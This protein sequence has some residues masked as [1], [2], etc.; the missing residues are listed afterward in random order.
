MLKAIIK[1][2]VSVVLVVLLYFN[3]DFGFVLREMEEISLSFLTIVLL[4]SAAGII[5]EVIKWRVLL[6]TV[7]FGVFFISFMYCEL[8]TMILPGQM[9]GEVAKIA[10]FGKHTGK[11]DLSIST[12]VIDKITAVMGLIIFGLTGLIFSKSE[13][14]GGFTVIL[15]A[16]AVLALAALFLLKS[17]K[18]KKLLITIVL[19]PRKI[20]PKFENI[21][22][23]AVGVI[24]TWREYL[25]KP[26]LIV[27]TLLYGL[28]LYTVLL[29]QYVVICRYYEIPV[30]WIDLCWIMPVVNVVQSIPISFAGIGVRD[31]S[32]VSMFAMIGLPAESAALLAMILFIVIISRTVIGAIFVLFDILRIRK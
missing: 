29:I 14:P 27:K 16:C 21:C 10:A 2:L 17:E 19:L 31:V 7:S 18:L 1:I 12:V 6:P 3:I 28:L 8:F 20:T 23:K 15:L 11:I 5:I 24:E 13:L 32:L 9:F 25:D 30:S 26:R 4:L 22:G